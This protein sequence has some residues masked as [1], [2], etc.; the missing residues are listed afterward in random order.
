MRERSEETNQTGSSRQEVYSNSDNHSLQPWSVEK[1]LKRHN[2]P[3]CKANWLQQDWN[4]FRNLKLHWNTGTDSSKLNTDGGK[5]IRWVFF[6]W[7]TNES[8]PRVV[9][10]NFAQIHW[11][12][13]KTTILWSMS[14][15]CVNKTL[16]LTFRCFLLPQNMKRWQITD[17][18]CLSST[19]INHPWCVHLCTHSAC[20]FQRERMWLWLADHS[21]RLIPKRLTL[22]PSL[23]TTFSLSD[24]N[25][26]NQLNGCR[27]EHTVDGWLMI[28]E[29]LL[30]EAALVCY[31][32]RTF[33]SW[34]LFF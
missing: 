26:L 17:N 33:T 24:I 13:S 32:L 6:N 12:S 29:N 22:L 28:L 18:T 8:M 4:P 21:S 25:M 19:K 7:E 5:K 15:F 10:E 23:H 11:T 34:I 3:N 27:D 31:S 1:H 20:W 16:N 14:V 30:P 9:A 2:I